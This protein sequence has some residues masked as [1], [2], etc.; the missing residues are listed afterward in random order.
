MG[1]RVRVSG[2]DEAGSGQKRPPARPALRALLAHAR[3]GLPEQ[4]VARL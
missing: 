4:A 2:A 3:S 1:R